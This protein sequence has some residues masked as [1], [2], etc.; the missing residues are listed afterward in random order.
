MERGNR[1]ENECDHHLYIS[2]IN[3]DRTLP[4]PIPALASAETCLDLQLFA[5]R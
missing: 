4:S 2:I 5:F 1:F 3:L